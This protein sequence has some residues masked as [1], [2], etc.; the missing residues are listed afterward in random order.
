MS[1]IY[2][3]VNTPDDCYLALI[4]NSYSYML[5]VTYIT[6]VLPYVGILSLERTEPAKYNLCNGQGNKSKL[7]PHFKIAFVDKSIGSHHTQ[8][9][10]SSLLIEIYLI[11]K[12][13]I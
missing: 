7:F 5:A 11:M 12:Q 1:T 3:I 9:I 10:F 4:T 6:A 2:V 13:N 8:H